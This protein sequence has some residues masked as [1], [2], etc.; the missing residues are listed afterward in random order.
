MKL[1]SLWIQRLMVGIALSVFGFAILFSFY[2]E[3]QRIQQQEQQRLRAQA[4]VIEE[5]VNQNLIVLD[6]VLTG[7][8]DQIEHNKIPADFNNYLMALSDAMPSVH[9]IVVIDVLGKVTAANRPELA[10][11]DFSQRFYFQT[12]KQHADRNTAYISAPF[13]T[14]LGIYAINVTRIL[15]GVRGEFSGIVAATLDPQ[16]FIPLLDSIRDV[17]DM[18]ATL[19]HWDG[20]AFISVPARNE[21]SETRF[22]EHAWFFNWHRHSGRDTTM[23]SHT[24]NKIDRDKMM[25]LRTIQPADIK[26]DK[27]LV[28]VIDR[29]LREIYSSWRREVVIIGGLYLIIFFGATFG[30]F[31]Y[32]RRQKRAHMREME[33]TRAIQTSERFMKAITDH[34]PAMMAYWTNEL[35]CRFAN[36]VYLEWFG[37]TQDEMTGIRMQDLLDEE[38]F[39][40]NEPFIRGALR[41]EPQQFQRTL[42]KADHS[43]G[44]TWVQYIPDIENGH[45]NGFYVLAS[46]ITPLKEAQDE[47]E[48][49]AQM[50]FLTGLANRRHFMSLG[51]QEL[52]RSCRYD[53]PLSVLMMDIDFF[54]KINDTYGHRCGDKV[55][56]RFAELCRSSIRSS[57]IIGRMGGEEFAVMLPHTDGKHAI[58]AA[59]H[60]RERIAQAEVYSDDGNVV[61]FTTSIGVAIRWDADIDLEKLLA[62]ADEAL[63]EAKHSGRNKVC[64]YQVTG[65]VS[66]PT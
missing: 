45:V 5:N 65:E 66:M 49:M 40:K 61:R 50:D 24:R 31:A 37:K 42:I 36:G 34:F 25:V 64:L 6:D 28:V 38:L 63:Y 10:N 12:A 20:K 13:V 35:R 58:E 43:V 11:L 59:E 1:D 44:Y 60:L 16:Y 7:I 3:N 27:P 18:S 14:A 26:L 54:K 4:H 9:T 21:M 41:G 15:T 47:L 30:L 22:L 32:E 46:D 56:Q 52:L 2:S 17:P 29:D 62:A 51:E 57:D 33:A 53:T 23:L 55:L 8:R 48:R 19:V 39:R